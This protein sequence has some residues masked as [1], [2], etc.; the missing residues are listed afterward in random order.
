MFGL[1]GGKVA[2][3]PGFEV[4]IELTLQFMR[5]AAFTT[6]LRSDE[7]R[8]QAAID[9]LVIKC[10][11]ALETTGHQRLVV[12]GGVSAN[13]LLRERMADMAGTQGAKVFYPRPEFCTDNGAMIAYTGCVRMAA[14][15]RDNLAFGAFPR[16]EIDSLP[17]V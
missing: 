1:F 2:E 13:Q 4:A 5:G 9:T 3:S 6:I 11:R 16:W 17:K 14:G 8:Q 12:A 7:A 15:Q 10:R